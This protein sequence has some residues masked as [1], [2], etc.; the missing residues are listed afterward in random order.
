LG[1]KREKTNNSTPR[2]LGL[3]SRNINFFYSFSSFFFQ[4]HSQNISSYFLVLRRKSFKKK[5][6]IME[7]IPREVPPAI[8]LKLVTDSCYA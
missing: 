6:E 8:I 5:I 3:I 7:D 2:N 1:V 4:F